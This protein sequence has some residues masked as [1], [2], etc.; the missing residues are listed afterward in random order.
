MIATISAPTSLAIDVAREAGVRLLGFCRNDG[1]VEYVS[2]AA[3][4]L[5]PS[6]APAQPAHSS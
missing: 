2:P 6:P 4:H 1:F 3:V 5:D